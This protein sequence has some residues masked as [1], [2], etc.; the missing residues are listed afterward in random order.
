MIS[1]I[2]TSNPLQAS[3]SLTSS[4][5]VTSDTITRVKE[6]GKGGMG[7]V[8]DAIWNGKGGKINVALKELHSISNFEELKNEVETITSLYHP[9]IIKVYGIEFF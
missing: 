6:L 9:Q 2:L 4:F 5:R 8:Y 3:I 1:S 7:K